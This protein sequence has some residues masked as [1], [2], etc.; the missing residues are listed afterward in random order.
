V[1][2]SDQYFNDKDVLGEFVADATRKTSDGFVTTTD[3]YQRF[4]EWCDKQGLRPWTLRTLQ[5]ELNGRGFVP[6]RRKYGR[7]FEGISMK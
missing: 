7:G 6:A 2:A 1:A 3:L 5:K 4:T